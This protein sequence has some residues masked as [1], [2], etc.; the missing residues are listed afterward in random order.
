MRA[1]DADTRAAAN[2]V[3]LTA[4]ETSPLVVSDI[5]SKEG[6]PSKEPSTVI[7]LSESEPTTMVSDDADDQI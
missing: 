6:G 4:E 2:F 3:D 1:I 5:V 7:N